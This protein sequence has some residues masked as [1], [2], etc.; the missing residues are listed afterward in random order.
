MIH[1]N[2]GLS[3]LSHSIIPFSIH[4][5]SGST[6]PAIVCP[7]IPLKDSH[8]VTLSELLYDESMLRKLTT[9]GLG[10][11]SHVVSRELHDSKG[12]ATASYNVLEQWRMGFQGGDIDA[13]QTLCAAMDKVGL[14]GLRAE[15][16]NECNQL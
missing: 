9:N 2:C 12:I 4:I 15:F 8:I 10:V 16:Q 1:K 14:S 3:A 13:Y 5:F 11:R 7:S 6:N